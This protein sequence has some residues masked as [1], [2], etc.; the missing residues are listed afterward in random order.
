MSPNFQAVQPQATN[1]QP[2]TGSL[3]G[4]A[5]AQDTPKLFTPVTSKSITLHNRIV[6][7]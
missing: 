5:I 4:S 2:E 7:R 1:T 3:N 6:V